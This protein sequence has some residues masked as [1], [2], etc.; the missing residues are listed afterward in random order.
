MTIDVKR[1]M[2]DRLTDYPTEQWRMA[3]AEFPPPSNRPPLSF[4]RDQRD[5][6]RSWL[7]SRGIA[8]DE[9][10]GRVYIG[11]TQVDGSYVEARS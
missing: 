10:A 3:L 1:Y 9:I 7:A 11:S 8:A 6:A 4:W 2:L 5:N